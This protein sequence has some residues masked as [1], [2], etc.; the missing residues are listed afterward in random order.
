MKKELIYLA[1]CLFSLSTGAKESVFDSGEASNASETVPS[2]G[3][4]TEVGPYTIEIIGEGV[5]H[6]QD[7][8]QSNPAGETFDANGVKTHFNN[9]SDMYLLVGSDRALLID[10]SNNVN[11]DKTASES[12]RSLV[13]ERCKGKPLTIT[14]THNHGDHTGML[15]AYI[16]DP[17]VEFALPRKDFE[18]MARRFP[19]GQYSFYDEGKVFDL[20]GMKVN[21]LLVPGHTH[22]SMVFFLEGRDMVFTGDA[23][24]SG[25]GVW[26]FNTE[27]FEE[28]VKAIPHLI[29]YIEDPRHGINTRKLTF[30]GGHYWQRDWFVKTKHKD[31]DWQ[32]LKDMQKLIGQ[33]AKG[34]A[35]HEPSNLDHNTLDTYFRLNNAIIV[36]NKK[37]A[38]DWAEGRKQQ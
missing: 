37:Q 24:G 29:E 38:E 34:K 17:T 21:T 16:N 26:I 33:I 2:T 36:W 10:L 19:T 5:Y 4:T 32:Y 23:I 25:H 31:I 3:Q 22:G 9:C 8:N 7:F 20:G 18:P 15:P 13:A 6:I 30:W 12:L 27:G 14:F 11:W 28:Y 35:K 1:F